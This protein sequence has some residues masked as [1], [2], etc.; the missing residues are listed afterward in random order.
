MKILT[1]IITSL[2]AFV[3]LTDNEIAYKDKMTSKIQ[4]SIA[5]FPFVKKV[6]E[7]DY[8]FQPSVNNAQIKDLCT[9]R[10]I[11]KRK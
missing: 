11:E 10:F 5:E 2:D 4:V 1:L 9:L 7:Y 3:H 8:T 6:K